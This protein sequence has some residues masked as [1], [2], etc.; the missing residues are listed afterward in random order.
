[1][2][3]IRSWRPSKT[4]TDLRRSA[5]WLVPWLLISLASMCLTWVVDKKVG[6]QTALE[7]QL[8]MQ[9]KRQAALDQL[10]PEKR[11]A[12]LK[13]GATITRVAAY[14]APALLLIFFAIGAGVLLGTFNFGFGAEL[15]FGRTLAV[16]MYA[17]LPSIVQV[18]IA[19]LAIML[20]G[21]QGFTFDNP[22]AS[23]LSGLVDYHLISSTPLQ[24]H[25]TFSPFGRS[26]SR[27]SGFP[28]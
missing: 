10:S 5:N 7:N 4:F 18:L 3:W 19:I 27:A 8:A 2:S 24:F 17:W 20:G 26:C 1:M 6:M 16:L 9:P 13:M 11:D 28:A 15:T 22:V 21:G 12:Q 14:C 23:N 25:S